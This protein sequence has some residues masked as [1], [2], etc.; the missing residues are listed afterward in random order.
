MFVDSPKDN[1]QSCQSSCLTDYEMH[2][3]SRQIMAVADKPILI[4]QFS[5]GQLR[6]ENNTDVATFAIS[7]TF[8]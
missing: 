8:F 4:Q 5:S 7:K 6:Y 1:Q 2:K 3:G